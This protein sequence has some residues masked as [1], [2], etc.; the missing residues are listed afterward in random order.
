M[1]MEELHTLPVELKHEQDFWAD[2]CA[3]ISKQESYLG[4][5]R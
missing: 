2:F 4:E 3:S 1:Y 5:M